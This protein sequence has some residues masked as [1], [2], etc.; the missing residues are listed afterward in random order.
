MLRSL[1]RQINSAS[2][3]SS[4]MRLHL[5]EYRTTSSTIMIPFSSSERSRSFLTIPVLRL[6]PR[7][8]RLPGKTHM[9]SGLSAL[10][11][12]LLDYVVPLNKRHLDRLLKE[13]V[14]AYYNPHRTPQGLGGVTPIP[15]RQYL[16][17]NA[18]ETTLRKTRILGGLYH[19]LEKVG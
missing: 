15:H 10:S 13:Y 4:V 5:T 12:A 11:G 2:R 17:T 18:A 3:N 6:S 1:I 19:T 8:K 7:R 9:P 14:N 16:P